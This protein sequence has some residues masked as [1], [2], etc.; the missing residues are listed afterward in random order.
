MAG[1]D[2]RHGDGG[3]GGRGGR[4][5]WV[6]VKLTAVLMAMAVAEHDRGGGSEVGC[7]IVPC[8]CPSGDHAAGVGVFTA[9]ISRVCDGKER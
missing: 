8:A 4:A 3:R 7:V 9:W 1:R 2:G 6:V 5:W